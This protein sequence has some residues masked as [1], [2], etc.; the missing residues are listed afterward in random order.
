MVIAMITW[1]G[2][3]LYKLLSPY[4]EAY[5]QLN[6]ET[7]RPPRPSHAAPLTVAEWLKRSRTAHQQRDYREAC[8]ALYMAALQRLNDAHSI[9]QE[10]SR[11]DGEYL[12][13][14]QTLRPSHAYQMLIHTHERL[15]FSQTAISAE[16]FDRCW[17]AYQEIDPLSLESIHLQP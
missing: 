8:R 17:Q 16:T 13:L 14:V 10:A 6:R 9:P 15:C 7:L 1:A 4:V 12:H 3:Q 11:T 2:W 5:W